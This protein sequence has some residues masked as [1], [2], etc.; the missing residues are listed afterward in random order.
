MKNELREKIATLG[1]TCTD[2]GIPACV[3]EAVYKFVTQD[4]KEFARELLDSIETFYFA[5]AT[6]RDESFKKAV[7]GIFDIIVEK[8]GL[9]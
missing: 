2:C 5:E 4:R 9:E 1:L 3:E 8:A 7:L 6:P